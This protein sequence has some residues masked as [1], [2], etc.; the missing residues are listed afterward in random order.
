[1]ANAVSHKATQWEGMD[2]YTGQM[3]AFRIKTMTWLTTAVCALG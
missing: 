1:M 2:H 3:Y